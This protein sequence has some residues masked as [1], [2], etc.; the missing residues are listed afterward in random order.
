MTRKPFDKATKALFVLAQQISEAQNESHI[1]PEHYLL[2]MM[3]QENNAAGQVLR[4]AGITEQTIIEAAKDVA[5]PNFQVREL[6]PGVKQALEFAINEADNPDTYYV[7]S[8]HVLLGLLQ[9]QNEP[10]I[11][12]MT[13]Q[14]D[15]TPEVLE[16]RARQS[17]RPIRIYV[18]PIGTVPSSEPDRLAESIRIY[19]RFVEGLA[20]FVDRVKRWFSSRRPPDETREAVKK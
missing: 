14:A 16:R 8:E 11:E 13:A 12:R 3:R 7:K 20:G 1:G 19:D 18:E 2:A 17:L 10:I 5:R 4:A 9:I 6:L 15:T